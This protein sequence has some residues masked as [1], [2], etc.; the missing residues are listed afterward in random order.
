ME[1]LE[2]FLAAR[3]NPEPRRAEG[4]L[5]QFAVRLAARLPVTSWHKPPSLA[6]DVFL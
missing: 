5:D 3:G 4:K 1:S 6:E 2:P